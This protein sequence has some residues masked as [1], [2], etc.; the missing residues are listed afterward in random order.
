MTTAQALITI[1]IVALA[2]LLLRALPFLA[3][4]ADRPLPKYVAYLGDALPYAIIGMLVV[5]CLKDVSPAVSPYGAPEA[6]GVLAVAGL[7]LWRKNT[8]LAIAAGTA[9]Y[10]LFVQL[11]WR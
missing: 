11:I 1:G 9:V 2:T 4:P 10:M 5:Y 8:L 6:L 7:Y 3:F